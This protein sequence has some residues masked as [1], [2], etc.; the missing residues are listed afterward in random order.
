MADQKPISAAARELAARCAGFMGETVGE[1]FRD[2]ARLLRWKNS[3]RIIDRAEQHL[4]NRKAQGKRTLPL[5]MAI[6]FMDE[7]S[8]EEDAD[9]QDLWARLLA[10]AADPKSGYAISKTHIALLAEMNG[11]D[12]I[13]LAS[14]DQA[15][16][17][18]FKEVAQMTG[19]E[20]LD[21]SRL[22]REIG[23]SENDVGLA[24][25]NLW[26]LGCLIQEPTYESG[27]G[28]STAPN[29][30]FRVSPLGNSLVKSVE[31]PNGSSESTT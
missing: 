26:R 29:S 1:L 15:H 25:G 21:C 6:R 10:N 24:L 9:V 7:A 19:N 30:T 23:Y 12:A 4:E 22:A 20:P 18:Q 27:V 13:V 3:H 28:P 8:L 11:L 17:M 2:E 5:G 16:W 14:I 31:V